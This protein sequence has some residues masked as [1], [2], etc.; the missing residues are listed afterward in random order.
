ME[1]ANSIATLSSN[2]DSL[3]T[4]F[5]AATY[6][7]FAYYLTPVMAALFTLWGSGSGKDRAAASSAWCSS[8][9]A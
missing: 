2:I 9:S 8:S 3:G 6:G 1:G 4:N 5:T 7:I